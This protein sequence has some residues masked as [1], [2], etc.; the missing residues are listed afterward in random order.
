M[1]NT[2]L[3]PDT[4][5]RLR[6]ALSEYAALTSIAEKI[7][8]ESIR[9]SVMDKIEAAKL[10]NLDR[11]AEIKNPDGTVLVKHPAIGF[12]TIDEVEQKEP[13]RLF[14]SRVKSMSTMRICV[15]QADALV[16]V[17][18]N[19]SYINRDL[20]MEV[21]MTQAA[22][23]GVVSVSN[24][25][26]FPMTIRNFD[27]APIEFEGDMNSVRNQLIMSDTQAMTTRLDGRVKDLLGKVMEHAAGGK[28][29]SAKARDEI[30][31]SARVVRSWTEENPAY[32]AKRLGEFTAQTTADIKMEVEA[33][34]QMKGMK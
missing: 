28:A 33:M 6:A 14:A 26:N 4:L 20:I 12:V 17:M 10:A 27:G 2:Y 32:Y 13:I 24:G 8:D 31:M 19:I 22:F 23:A 16:D 15:H 21:E 29:L 3:T 34:A 11:Y 9:I 5:E 18:G 1:P 30:N 7:Q 25:E